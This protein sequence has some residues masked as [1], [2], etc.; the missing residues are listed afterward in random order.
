MQLS[1][2]IPTRNRPSSLAHCLRALRHALGDANPAV[3]VHVIDDCSSASAAER[4]RTL[5]RRYAASYERLPRNRGMSVARSIGSRRAAGEWIAFLDD[6][7]VVGSSWFEELSSVIAGGGPDMVGI[8]GKVAGSGEGVWDREVQNLR[9]GLYLTC[10]IIYRADALRRAGGFDEHFEY[11]GPFH[12]DHELAARMLQLGSIP[13]V[14]SI[15]AI[16]LPRSVQLG[17]QILAA[18]AR[19]RRLVNAEMYFY[20][21]QRPHYHRFRHADS[22]WGTYLAIA[23][24]HTYTA[25]HRR[26]VRTLLRHPI[27]TIALVAASLSEQVTAWILLPALLGR[28]VREAGRLSQPDVMSIWFAAA[29]PGTSNGGVA[30]N[31]RSLAAGLAAR[32]HVVRTF[33]GAAEGLRSCY[34]T[35]AF[36][37]GARLLMRMLSPPD[38]IVARSGD[39]VFCAIVAKCLRRKTAILLHN[40]GWEERIVGLERSAPAGAW[41]HPHTTFKARLVRLPLLRLCYRLCDACV[42]GTI[43]DIRW[44]RERYPRANTRH[45]YVPNGVDPAPEIAH[46]SGAHGP[47]RFLC[48][49]AFVWRKNIRHTLSVF[50][51][52]RA[53]HPHSELV[54]LGCGQPSGIPEVLDALGCRDSV[55]LVPEAP[56]HEMSEWYRRCPCSISSSRYEGGHTLAL[57]EAMS[58]GCVVF[59]SDIPAHRE[60]IRKGRNGF[61][62]TGVDAQDDARRVLEALSDAAALTAVRES[63]ARTAARHN[64]ARQVRRLERM[65]PCARR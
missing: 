20:L 33:F 8:E 9:G 40:H 25:L 14:P 59:A 37:M 38:I 55:T 51:R 5:S 58:F 53:M 34:L 54:L 61:L 41:P 10:H 43:T 30:R 63:A 1:V 19:M 35:F 4:N 32:G 57:L 26:E 46:H 44:L 60:F 29:V 22:F 24:R 47:L 64:W 31:V 11:E 28:Y 3:D 18:P 13:F 16:H 7:V 2:V 27:Q 65:L 39:A 21:K 17:G 52:I 36:E 49:G 12:E 56:M 62:I 6:D 50:S 48:V 23:M 42:C 45:I 15:A